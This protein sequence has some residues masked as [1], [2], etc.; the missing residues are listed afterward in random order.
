MKQSVHFYRIIL[1]IVCLDPLFIAAS[2][3]SKSCECTKIRKMMI[4]APSFGPHS[5]QCAFHSIFLQ[6]VP[7]IPFLE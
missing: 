1:C 4:H 6:S 3:C 2:V 5:H 7:A